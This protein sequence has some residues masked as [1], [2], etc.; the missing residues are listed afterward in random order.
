MYHYEQCGNLYKTYEY[1]VKYLEPFYTITYA[2]YPM[3]ARK[4]VFSGN[5]D[6]Y[7]AR[8]DELV[9]L[10]EEIKE[11]QE[12]KPELAPHTYAHR[13]SAGKI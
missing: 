12:E 8:E 7:Y 13:V 1:K 4:A 2:L 3:L 6:G 5:I 9:L 10:A 11:Q